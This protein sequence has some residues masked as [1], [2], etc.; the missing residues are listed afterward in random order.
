MQVQSRTFYLKT[1]CKLTLTM[2][3]CSTVYATN[4]SKLNQDTKL[5]GIIHLFGNVVNY[6]L[7]AWMKEAMIK[8][9]QSQSNKSIESF[10]T[11]RD[12]APG[13]LLI[14]MIPQ[15]ETFENWTR[16]FAILAYH[17]HKAP[18]VKHIQNVSRSIY[19]ESCKKLSIADEVMTKKII[20]QR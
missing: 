10:K 7:P 2:L 11:C 12:E 18:T 20:K 15:N 6:P 8:N 16:L 9:A 14:E 4:T 13:H 17:T 3:L 1:L 5:E 19:K